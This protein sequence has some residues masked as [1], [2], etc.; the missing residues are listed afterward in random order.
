VECNDWRRRGRQSARRPPA[1]SNAT[2]GAA[3]KYAFRQT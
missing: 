1:I 2:P 3:T